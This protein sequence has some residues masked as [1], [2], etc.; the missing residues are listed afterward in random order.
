M[1][2]AASLRL[3]LLLLAATRPLPPYED[4]ENNLR[5]S[6]LVLEAKPTRTS[7]DSDADDLKLCLGRPVHG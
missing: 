6:G 2:A 5:R 3:I 7:L 1:W 4:F